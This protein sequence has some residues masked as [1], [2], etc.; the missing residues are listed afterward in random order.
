MAIESLDN[1]SYWKAIIDWK[2]PRKWYRDDEYPGVYLGNGDRDG[3]GIYRFERRQANQ[4]IGRENLYIGIAFQQVFDKRLHQGFHEWILKN[5]KRGQIWVSV[6][7]IDL[8]GT[9]HIKQR[10]EEIEA[11]LIYFTQP[12]LNERKK[13]LCPE[14][15]LEIEN[16]GYKGPLPRYIKYPVAEIIY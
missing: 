4:K 3:Y 14:C 7:I 1:Y 10:Y 15:Y 6:G 11:L 12:T 16:I 9:K 13:Y 8:R 2:P 5:V